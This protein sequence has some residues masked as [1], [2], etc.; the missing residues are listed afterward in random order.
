MPSAF[1]VNPE[2]FVAPIPGDNPSGRRVSLAEVNQLKQYQ[3]DFDPERDLSEEDR[4]NPQFAE[5]KR[6]MPRWDAIVEFGTKYLTTIGKDLEVAVRMV[7]ALTKQQ[8]GGFAGA[9]TGFRLLRRLCE[10]CWDRMHPALDPDDPDAITDRTSKL[11]WLDD[12]E[13][14]P[15]Y[16][17]TLRGIPL[18]ETGEGVEISFLTCQQSRSR[19]PKVSP[20]EFRQ[21]VNTARPSEIDRDS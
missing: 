11:E 6:V 17:T 21:A 3:E 19:A 10:E 1:V 15:Y 9:K 14:K 13:K 16:P 18:L 20:D 12:P 8:D 7:E 4:R 5:A 2:E